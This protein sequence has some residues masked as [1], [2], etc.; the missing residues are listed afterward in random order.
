VRTT[1]SPNGDIG[2]NATTGD[3][4]FGIV[5]LAEGSF[6]LKTKY[7]NCSLS[8]L[9]IFTNISLQS[10][11]KSFYAELALYHLRGISY[12]HRPESLF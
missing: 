5:T 8:L 12:S 2:T 6:G 4:E 10:S 3:T 7:Y 9:S 1:L 11:S